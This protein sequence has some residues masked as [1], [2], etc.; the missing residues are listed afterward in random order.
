MLILVYSL[1]PH[2]LLAYLE[3]LKNLWWLEDPLAAFSYIMINCMHGEYRRAE[4]DTLWILGDVSCFAPRLVEL[5][6]WSV[7]CLGTQWLPQE[8]EH[9]AGT[10][11]EGAAEESGRV[12]F[13]HDQLAAAGG[14]QDPE[15]R[16]ADCGDSQVYIWLQAEPALTVGMY[17]V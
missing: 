6:R 12:L 2:L 14:W 8:A 15:R 3:T 9:T 1:Y 16:L 13:Q 7:L 11:Q 17:G 10:P 5:C 4:T